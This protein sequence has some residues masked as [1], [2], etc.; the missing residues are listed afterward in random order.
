MLAAFAFS[1]IL[2]KWPRLTDIKRGNSDAA[3]FG[4]EEQ[5]SVARPKEE[6]I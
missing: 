6:L 4:G 1:D 2:N 3:L 5:W